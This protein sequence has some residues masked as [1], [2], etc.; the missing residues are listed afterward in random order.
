[1]IRHPERRAHV[2]FVERAAFDQ[3]EVL[4][5]EAPLA[6]NANLF[7]RKPLVGRGCAPL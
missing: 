1:L 4:R 7:L 6:R 2:C 3:P 5:F